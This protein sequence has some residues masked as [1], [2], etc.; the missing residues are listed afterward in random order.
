MISLFQRSE[1]G[2]KAGAV[3]NVGGWSRAEER[4]IRLT[5]RAKRAEGE[6]L[7]VLG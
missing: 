4:G 7:K 1:G 2:C 3:M 6:S 5:G